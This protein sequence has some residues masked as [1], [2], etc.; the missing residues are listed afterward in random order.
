MK[1]RK[2][3]KIYKTYLISIS[4]ALVVCLDGIFSGIA[5]NIRKLI[6][7]EVLIQAKAHF[8][9]IVIARKWNA[10]YNGVY[11]EKTPGMESNPYLQHP[12]IMTT[13]GRIYTMKNPALMMREISELAEAEGLVKFH[14]TSLQL[15]N[16]ENKPDAF[17]KNH[18]RCLSRAKKRV[19]VKK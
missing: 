18:C 7:E 13:D 3:A 8:D 15:M 2:E 6:N 10:N 14:I 1:E 9:Q 17:E 16:P 5:L 12:D 19:S 11:V 4:L